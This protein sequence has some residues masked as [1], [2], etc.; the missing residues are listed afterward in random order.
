MRLQYIYC[1]RRNNR[2]HHKTAITLQLPPG[3]L[4]AHGLPAV[5]S[6]CVRALRTDRRVLFMFS[7]LIFNTNG[8]ES[9]PIKILQLFTGPDTSTGGRRLSALGTAGCK[10][11]KSEEAGAAA[12]RLYGKVLRKSQC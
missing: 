4:K 10:P 6:L 12:A 8:L 11:P 7:K 3:A 9:G 5:N 1:A 2:A